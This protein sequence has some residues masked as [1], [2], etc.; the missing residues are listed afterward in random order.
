[1]EQVQSIVLLALAILLFVVLMRMYSRLPRLDLSPD[2]DP[3]RSEHHVTIPVRL[4]TAVLT[5]AVLLK[6]AE[7]AQTSRPAMIWGGA[8]LP[9]L[10][11][12]NAYCWQ[13]KAVLQG[14]DLTIMTPSFRTK[15]FD[16]TRLINV[17]SEAHG[18]YRLHFQGGHTATLVKYVNGHDTLRHALD[19]AQPYY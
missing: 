19:K 8:I 7:L 15:T 2:K 6:M 18:T 17:Q 10:A 3:A 13:F 5:M 16:L 4:A 11:Y 1:M 14:S 9:I 12:V